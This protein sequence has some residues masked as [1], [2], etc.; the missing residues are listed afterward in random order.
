MPRMA[1]DPALTIYAATLRQMIQAIA[2]EI[3]VMDINHDEAVRVR[4]ER[5]RA[6]Q[7]ELDGLAG[8]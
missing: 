5:A 2:T 8:K 7:R 4:R 1:P 3:G 6:L